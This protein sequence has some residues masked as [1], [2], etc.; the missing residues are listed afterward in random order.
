M[1]A[2]NWLE[3]NFDHCVYV[4]RLQGW[5]IP[6]KRDTVIP[7]VLWREFWRDMDAYLIVKRVLKGD[8]REARP[9]PPRVRKAA[10]EVRQH[11]TAP[12]TE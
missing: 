8:F 2:I 7:R 12:A 5:R 6:G 10:K 9:Q 1:K 11:E 3:E 4:A